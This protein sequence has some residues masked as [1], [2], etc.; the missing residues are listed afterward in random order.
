MLQACV[1]D[2]FGAAKVQRRYLI[3][4]RKYSEILVADHIG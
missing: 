4:L 1:G 2:S 3:E